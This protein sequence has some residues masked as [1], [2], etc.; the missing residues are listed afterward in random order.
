MF[1]VAT[2][3][4]LALGGIGFVAALTMI[5]APAEWL[6]AWALRWLRNLLTP[7]V[8]GVVVMLVAVT[9]APLSIGAWQG[10]GTENA[11]SV[12]NFVIGGATFVVMVG[13]L[14]LAPPKLRLWRSAAGPGGG[15]A[16]SAGV[17]RLGVG[18]DA[19]CSDCG[20]SDRRMDG[21]DIPEH[22]GGLG[23]GGGV[24]HRH[25]ERDAGDGG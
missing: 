10:T 17:R 21:A 19:G 15:G 13:I 14:M 9:V 18:A 12:E 24:H 11:E 8:G 4:A 1:F 20:L 3:D 16:D 6:F 5:A 7:A 25:A 22:G 2:Q 23:D